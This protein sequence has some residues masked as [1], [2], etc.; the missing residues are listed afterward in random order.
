MSYDGL[1]LFVSTATHRYVVTRSQILEMRIITR[2][3]DIERPDERGKPITAHSLGPLLDPADKDVP[4]RHHALIIPTRR[5]GIALLVDRVQ[6]VYQ[7]TEDDV[8]K[9]PPLFLRNIERPWFLGI[10]LYEEEPFLVLDLRQIAQ[11]ILL[12]KK[13]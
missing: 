12:T 4:R 11:N 2:Q 13:K 1:L 10:F 9:L 5:R 3:A 8:Q 7:T 6:D